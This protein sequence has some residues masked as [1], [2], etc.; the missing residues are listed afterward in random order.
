MPK[1]LYTNAFF[2]ISVS[3]L[4]LPLRFFVILCICPLLFYSLFKF[5]PN[6]CMVSFLNFLEYN[7]RMQGAILSLIRSMIYVDLEGYQYDDYG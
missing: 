1:I 6:F 7:F 2:H 3:L 5:D 4:D